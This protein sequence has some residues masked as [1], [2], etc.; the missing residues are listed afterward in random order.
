MGTLP[1]AF[2]L[3][4]LI[5]LLTSGTAADQITKTQAIFNGSTG[6]G[7]IV[8]T[9]SRIGK[10]EIVAMEVAKEDFYGFGNLTFLLINDSQKDTIHA[11]LEAK[12]LIDTRQVQAIIGPQT[13]EEVSLVAE[14]ARETQVPILSFA[15]T[16][17][18]WAT[19]RWPSL[20]Q[21]SPDKRAQMKAVA[22]I[23]QSWNWHQVTVIYE[24]TDSSAR[25]VI[26]HLHDALREVNS[27]VSQFVAFSPFASSDSM[28]KEL[29]NIKSKQYCR[30]F[31]VH[32][33]FKLAVRLF[34]MANKMEMM[35]KDFVWITTDPITSLVHSINASV[36]SSMQ[37]I[38]GVRSYFPKMGRHF[39]T[40]NQRFSTRFSRKY[41]REEKKEPG[42][43]AV[44][45]YDAMRTIA[46]GL[47]KTG[48]KRGG[49]ELL[50][51]ILDADFHGLSGKVKFKNQNVAAAEIFEIVN[52]I[53]TGYNELGYWSN[54]L[55]FSENIHENSSYNTSMIG[56][57]Q[58]YWPGGPRYTPRGWTALTSAKRLR[59][60]V[61]SISGYEEYVKVES[62]DRLGTNFSGFSIEVFKATAASMPSFPLYEFQYFNGS[63]DKLVEQIHLK[64]FDAVVGDVEIVSSRYQYAEFTNPYTETGLVLIVPARSSSKA[65]SFVKPFTTT[66]WVLIS[67]ITVYNGFVVWWIE[68]EHCDELQGSIPNQIGIM[69]W[70]SFNTLFSLNGP[71]LH[72][73][74]SRMSGVVWLFV[75]LII[76]QTYTANLTSMLTVQRLEPIIPSVEELLN[77]NAMVGYCTGSY[78]ERYLAEVLKFKSQNLKHFRSAENYFEGFKDK[79]ISAAFLGTPYAKIFLAKYCNSFIQIGPTYKIGGFGF[80]FPRGSP[81][82]AS[83]NEAL[84]K[85]SENGTLQELE[86]TWISP[87]K[88]PEMPSDSSSLGPSGFR[89]LFFITGGTT[90]IAFVI[91]VC[92][93]N[94]LRLKN[95]WGIISAVLK[96][97]LSS[98]RQVTSRRVANVEIPPKAFPEAPVSLA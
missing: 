58:V 32:L 50:E 77:S 33:S 5:L 49:K 87:Q 80:A 95:M 60:G 39:E 71:K 2:S 96:R 83:V 44:Q 51:N 94:L 81:L 61:P 26:P 45:V 82:L 42:I 89:V 65:W 62:D 57:G 14:I 43:Y 25:G 22:A 46:L 3:F 31:V 41:P 52:V 24:D 23:V 84:L 88:C 27:E 7:A 56:L 68:R 66:M 93:P 10:E 70:L 38:L 20:L 35:K 29:E 19:E 17:P 9:S 34:E 72:S 53:G 13:W 16:A 8:D 6:I 79:N 98:R 36:I 74:L 69:I 30:V 28:S 86:K 21:A 92:R 64:N 12:D 55:G 47:I 18:E 11:A 90:T 67:V 40:F 54:G 78:M 63:Y 73:N 59:I 48:S 97:W 4:A 85:I 15:D 75:A 37:G 76:T 1:H 91:Y